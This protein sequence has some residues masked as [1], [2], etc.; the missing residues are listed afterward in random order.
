MIITID[1]Y[2]GTGKSTLAKRLAEEYNFIYIEKPFIKMVQEKNMCSYVEAQI[3]ALELEK[4]LYVNNLREEKIRFYSNALVWLKSYAKDLNIVL[5][6]GILT[7]YAVYGEKSTSDI[8]KEYINLGV[9][10]DASIYLIADDNERIRR[11]RKNDPFDPDLKYP[12]KWRDHNL[13]EFCDNLNLNRYTIITDNKSIDDVFQE[14]TIHF[15]KELFKQENIK[16]KKL[17][18]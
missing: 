1:G 2:D 12:T 16:E 10:F 15:N 18:R 13:D 17:I 11:I 7:A 3:I 8:F 6:R 4:Q 5:D 14:A 9:F